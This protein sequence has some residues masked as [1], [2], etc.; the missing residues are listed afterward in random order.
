[1]GRTQNIS[2]VLQRHKQTLHTFH[3]LLQ[4]GV[5]SLQAEKFS[6]NRAGGGV[7]RCAGRSGGS[8]L[9]QALVLLLQLLD[10]RAQLEEP[11]TEPRLTTYHLL[12]GT[13]E[14]RYFLS[15]IH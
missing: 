12:S 2:R 15:H 13:D 6:I 7:G 4:G 3:L 8:S 10:L 5:L 1:M 11:R 14:L 9:L